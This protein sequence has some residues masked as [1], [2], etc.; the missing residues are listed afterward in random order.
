M[1]LN[2]IYTNLKK[3]IDLNLNIKQTNI[4]TD[5]LLKITIDS[6]KKNLNKNIF[7]NKKK[8]IIIKSKIKKNINSI[9]NKKNKIIK[10]NINLKKIISKNKLFFLIKEKIINFSY[11]K[12]IQKK[13]KYF[14]IKIILII[15]TLDFIIASIFLYSWINDLKNINKTNITKQLNNSYIKTSIS[16]FLYKPFLLIPNH[17]I[18][19]IINTSE[20]IKNI[21]KILL[22]Y[23][24]IYNK[25]EKNSIFITDL[26]KDN[27]KEILNTLINIKNTNIALKNIKIWAKSKYFS[28]YIFLKDLIW[29]LELIISKYK[30]DPQIILD[31]L[32]DKKIKKYIILFQNNDE[33]RA[34]WGFPWSVWIISIYKW[35]IIDFKKEDIYNL[36]WNINKNYKKKIT[37]P[38]WLKSINPFF[39]LKDSNYYSS[40]LQSSMAI[41]FFLQKWW[42]NFNWII[43]I[44][45]NTI[46][47]ILNLIWWVYFKRINTIINWNNFNTIISLL[48]ESKISKQWTLWT[49]KKILFDFTKLFKNKIIKTHKYLKIAQIINNDIKNREISFI[50]FNKKENTLFQNLKLNWIIN[51]NKYQNFIYPIF[52]SLS[53]NKSDRYLKISYNININKI[54]NKNDLCNY[55]TSLNINLKHNFN[56]EKENEILKQMKKYHIPITKNLL[57]IQWQWNN[58]QYIR[59]IIPS[60]TLINKK[61][62]INISKNNNTNLISFYTKINPWEDKNYQIKYIQSNL[63]CNNYI[64]WFLK[65]AWIKKYNINFTYKINNILKENII[66]NNLTKDFY[67]KIDK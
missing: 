63:T 43:F 24:N 7:L 4:F 9:T 13:K 1:K 26:I 50:L 66:K 49:P 65:Q 16:S 36:E 14:I 55:I 11:K 67:I 41:N 10:K 58:K 25:N 5:K 61:W 33:L 62:D 12:N 59:L 28:D 40:F 42:Y 22:T 56:K 2:D 47:K 31:I 20:A 3:T 51:Y 39:T 18:S 15:I 60:K 64:F 57:S 35:E 17:Y 23:Y 29:K 8:K 34:T 52:T 32:W 45:T 21:N 19:N 53:Q 54:S 48:V 46:N 27:K 37:S 44:N 6:L 38:E 30:K